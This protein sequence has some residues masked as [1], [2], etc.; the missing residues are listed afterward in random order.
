VSIVR[1]AAKNLV[2]GK[3]FQSLFHLAAKSSA[4]K[5]AQPL[6]RIKDFV[7]RC[8]GWCVA[9][10]IAVLHNNLA[11]M[12]CHAARTEFIMSWPRDHD[13]SH[14]FRSGPPRATFSV[15]LTSRTEHVVL[16][17]SPEEI[18]LQGVLCSKVFHYARG[19]AVNAALVSLS[20]CRPAIAAR[21]VAA[22]SVDI[23]RYAVVSS[24]G[25]TSR[26]SSHQVFMTNFSRGG[27]GM[28]YRSRFQYGTKVLWRSNGSAVRLASA[29]PKRGNANAACIAS[30][31]ARHR[32]GVSVRSAARR[33]DISIDQ[34]RETGGTNPRPLGSEFCSMAARVEV[35]I[36]DLLLGLRSSSFC[37]RAH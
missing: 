13:V 5:I 16:V 31:A 17:T 24:N 32:Q 8:N 12:T 37:A 11:N 10:L 33:L 21:T 35:P 30:R 9:N 26:R 14:G 22:A 20:D 34:S 25:R 23:F 27:S 18:I 29:V 6:L 2:R 36:N 1:T 15:C 4:P 7:L 19:F 28:E 3:R